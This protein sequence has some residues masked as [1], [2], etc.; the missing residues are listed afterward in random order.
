MGDSV[1]DLSD[2]ELLEEWGDGENSPQYVTTDGAGDVVS[3]QR[4]KPRKKLRGPSLVVRPLPTAGDQKAATRIQ[5]RSRG[6]LERKRTDF[7]KDADTILGEAYADI[8]WIRVRAMEEANRIL[9]ER[10]HYLDY[11]M[12]YDDNDQLQPVQE[13]GEISTP[14]CMV[15][16]L[17]RYHPQLKRPAIFPSEHLCFANLFS[18]PVLALIRNEDTDEMTQL[19]YEC[20]EICQRCGKQGLAHWESRVFIG[21]VSTGPA[22]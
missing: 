12:K 11:W 2:L 8:A 14:W 16:A 17:I 3:K 19:S 21:T 22:S 9:T 6:Y 15:F 4:G 1:V 5:A 10:L 13:L 7:Y 18:P 20:V